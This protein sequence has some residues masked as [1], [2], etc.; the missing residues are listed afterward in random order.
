MM[1]T[2]KLHGVHFTVLFPK[3]L[4]GP[5]YWHGLTLIPTWVSNHI[6]SKVWDEITYLFR[7]CNIVDIESGPRSTKVSTISADDLVECISACS[8]T[9]IC[10]KLA[11]TDIDMFI[12]ISAACNGSR[13]SAGA[14]LTFKLHMFSTK[15]LWLTMITNHLYSLDDII[16]NGW[17]DLENCVKDSLYTARAFSLLLH[18]IIPHRQWDLMVW[19]HWTHTETSLT[20]STPLNSLSTSFYRKSITALGAA[21]SLARYSIFIS[22]W[23]PC[24]S[25]ATG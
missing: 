17:W 11:N 4:R 14:V 5:F 12:Q 19:H 8:W 22:W 21:L 23:K 3:Y 13:P 2:E 24:L 7:D 9:I 20:D 10:L 1:Y 18:Q 15:F 16:Q 6:H 25:W